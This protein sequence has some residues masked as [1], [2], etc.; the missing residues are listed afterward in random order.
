MAAEMVIR[1]E[2]LD[3]TKKS[4]GDINRR[5]KDTDKTA[6]KAA[7]E[8]ARLGNLN[9]KR[10]QRALGDL[11]TKAEETRRKL[12]D[13]NQ[14]KFGGLTSS[15][16]SIKGR[17]LG[18]G[19]V[20]TGVVGGFLAL[21]NSLAQNELDL[22]R[23]SR[24]TGLAADSVEALHERVQILGA[25]GDVIFESLITVTEKAKLAMIQGTTATQDFAREF[26]FL[27]TAF[28]EAGG[29]AGTAED[30]LDFLA[31]ALTRSDDP[32]TN[33]AIAAGLLGDE[34]AKLLPIFSQLGDEGVAGLV[35]AE[36]AAGTLTSQENRDK[37]LA[38]AKAWDD[39]KR[40]FLEVGR[41]ILTSVLPPVTSVLQDFSGVL[42]DPKFLSGMQ[43]YLDFLGAL[44]NFGWT[45]LTSSL[46]T[47]SMGIKEIISS[48]GNLVGLEVDGL[49]S[50]EDFIKRLTDGLNGVSDT[51]RYLGSDELWSD[52]SLAPT[53]IIGKILEALS[54]FASKASGL[55]ASVFELDTEGIL[56]VFRNIFELFVTIATDPIGQVK[57]LFTT[58]WELLPEGATEAITGV[59][60][61][62]GEKA[63][64]AVD[65]VLGFIKGLWEK[66]P[67]GARKQIGDVFDFFWK[68]A[69]SAIDTV[70]AFFQSLW[71]DIS[72]DGK[73]ILVGFFNSLPGA[74]KAPVALILGLFVG[75]W[76]LIPQGAKDAIAAP[77]EAL[78]KVASDVV[79]EVV[80]FFAD[81]FELIPIKGKDLAKP[82][83]EFEIK[84]KESA[85]YF[86]ENYDWNIE[87]TEERLDEFW[88]YLTDT[89]GKAFGEVHTKAVETLNEMKFF[90]GEATTEVSRVISDGS[91]AARLA[92]DDLRRKAAE[93]VA[94]D[95]FASLNAS[96]G[97]V[98]VAAVQA[99]VELV[100]TGAAVAIAQALASGSGEMFDPA[101]ILTRA[102]SQVQSLRSAAGTTVQSLIQ[103]I[104]R[105]G[106]IQ[107]T[108]PSSVYSPPSTGT[109]T[110]TPET[111]TTDDEEED[112]TITEEAGP[113]SVIIDP[114]AGQPH[115]VETLRKF[116][117]ENNEKAN[118]GLSRAT[119]EAAV[120]NL[121]LSKI[122]IPGLKP[123]G[124]TITE[125]AGEA[126]PHTA[127]EIRDHIL[128]QIEKGNHQYDRGRLEE[129][130][131]D[132]YLAKT[133]IPGLALGGIV[134]KPTLAVVGEAGPEAVIP[135]NKGKSMGTTININVAGSVFVEDLEQQIDFAVRRGIERYA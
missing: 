104:L 61:F 103:H 51:I 26:G 37:T 92:I 35:A 95:P 118:Q 130:V 24:V 97:G 17:M 60:D 55:I 128:S 94:T 119:I 52:L 20:V 48:I 45:V 39:V 68:H 53:L 129:I 19:A 46:N 22:H 82:L 101:G 44:A 106:Q 41:S 33:A 74:V 70:L 13:I 10:S 25:D 76:K 86:S 30:K 57:L 109:G 29:A 21:A 34:A 69:K 121:Y 49:G 67:E 63:G 105:E 123:R 66:L 93:A 113:P 65:I 14:Q 80:G 96:L 132:I 110:G 73:T 62:L 3:R 7:D 120:R 59:F 115:S 1:A 16:D 15:L 122:K 114:E 38:Y 56:G 47:V 64:A 43:L 72:D 133:R 77:F 12:G 75:L 5:L 36:R 79:T 88:Y 32:L 58:L 89:S 6:D 31:Q 134:T 124:V 27:P 4:F 40:A 8:M 112:E 111:V 18:V 126:Q 117:I 11:N 102:I 81:A 125:E 98:T 9:T 85:E 23:W 108:L 2:M 87:Q 28:L 91:N 54:T 71:K 99:Q 135:L 131:K 107:T 50:F 100:A 84:A 78:V 116:V 83:R 90:L 42:S 127:K